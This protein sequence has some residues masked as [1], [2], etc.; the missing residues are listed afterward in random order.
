MRRQARA[1]DHAGRSS[2]ASP[3][4]GCTKAVALRSSPWTWTAASPQLLDLTAVAAAARST[5]IAL[6]RYVDYLMASSASPV[7]FPPVFID[8]W[9]DD[10]RRRAAPA[11]HVSGQIKHSCW[12][13]AEQPGPARQPVRDRQQSAAGHSPMHHRPRAAGGAANQRRVD[14][15]TREQ[16]PGAGNDGCGAA[17]LDGA[18]CR[19][20]TA[21]WANRCRRPRTISIPP[22]CSA[23]SS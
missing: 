6:P 8:G 9:P 12:Q 21:T 20:R 3:T 10:G 17:R 14:G 22:S 1:P 4:R 18:V 23:S 11:P 7:A 13:D 15:R 2:T 16:F 19:C 5:P